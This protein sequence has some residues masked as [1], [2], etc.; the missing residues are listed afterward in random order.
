MAASTETEWIRIAIGSQLLMLIYFTIDN[1]LDLYPWNNLR[2]P[3]AE[4]RSTLAGWI[5]FLLIMSAFALRLRW[6]MLVGIVYAYVWLL[7]QIRQWWI[8]Y[9]FGP[10]SLH[11]DF[12]WYYAHG[13][14]ETIKVLPPIADH[15]IPD[16]QHMVLQLLSL[17]V[18]VT[19]T[20]ACYKNWEGEI[21]Q[22]CRRF[23]CGMTAAYRTEA[24]K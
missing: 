16:L 6:A 1:H 18:A 11:R 19:A 20:V 15:P 8:L 2:S 5:P 22:F 17:T 23:G 7:L 3:A 4:L 9:L 12:S 13:Y 24:V 21:E 10:T 14:A